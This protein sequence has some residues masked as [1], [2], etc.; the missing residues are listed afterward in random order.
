M[1]KRRHNLL[2]LVAILLA[3]YFLRLHNLAFYSLSGDEAFSA[4]NWLARDVHYLLTEIA[5]ID[6]QPPVALL[7]FYGWAAGVGE[8]E[9]ALRYLSVTASMLMVASAYRIGLWF[10]DGRVGLLAAFL[11]ASSMQAIWNAQDARQ[12]ALWMGLSALNALLLIRV[13]QHPDQKS[14]WFI[15]GL[16]SALAF[17]TYYLEVFILI[18]HHLCLAVIVLYNRQFIRAWVT[19]LSVTGLLTIPWLLRPSLLNSGYAPTGGRPKPFEALIRQFAGPTFPLEQTH[20]T[21]ASAMAAAALLAAAVYLLIKQFQLTTIWLIVYVAFPILL[22]SLFT[23]VTGEGYF[24]SRYTVGGVM[25]LMLMLALTLGWLSKQNKLAF[26]VVVLLI[27]GV[28]AISYWAYFEL[29]TYAKAPPWSQISDYLDANVEEDDLVVRNIPGPAYDYYLKNRHQHVI[30]P[31]DRYA[32]RDNTDRYLQ[33]ALSNYDRLWFMPVQGVWDQEQVVYSYLVDNAQLLSDHWFGVS[34]VMQFADYGQRDIQPE[35]LRSTDFASTVH[36][37]GYTVQQFSTINQFPEYVS[38]IWEPIS[39][40]SSGLTTFMH[41]IQMPSG[42]LVAQDDHLPQYGRVSSEQWANLEQYRDVYYLPGVGLL[43]VG[44]YEIR[45]GWYD[46]QTGERLR[47]TAGE[48]S[49]TLT[50]VEIK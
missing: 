30:V 34:R 13:L 24:R 9:F 3:A 10:L 37:V 16:S 40:A 29:P 28:N 12:Y 22:L 7:T 50:E 36:L 26:A 19:S 27:V 5:V 23:I 20:L 49:V 47:T 15:F 1:S 35:T 33:T 42:K 46:V 31:L 48:D 8:S 14:R 6:P 18:A 11:T 41:V 2:Y 25:P 43:P 4:V 45:V 21:I 32:S 39:D 17:H 44:N 38:V